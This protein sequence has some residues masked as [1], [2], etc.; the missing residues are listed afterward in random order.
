MSQL[1]FPKVMLEVLLK[2][3][4]EREEIAKTEFTKGYARGR[5]D[6]LELLL[7]EAIEVEEK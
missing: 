1:R 5:A 2:V 6:M 7:D 3:N 4:R